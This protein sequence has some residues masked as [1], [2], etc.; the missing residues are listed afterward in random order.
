MRV[1]QSLTRYKKEGAAILLRKANHL[2][3]SGDYTEAIN[4]LKQ[5]EELGSKDASRER[6]RYEAAKERQE[7][8]EEERQARLARQKEREQAKYYEGNGNVQIAV[9][10][11]KLRHETDSHVANRNSTYV[12]VGIAARNVGSDIVHVNPNDFTLADSNGST[13]SHESDTY[14]LGNYFDAVDLRPGQNTSG[15][16]IF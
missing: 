5:A 10:G 14:S 1:R 13:A 16:L 11:A 3:G 6:P 15:W 12:Y 9:Y 4:V 2:Y 7:R 8:A